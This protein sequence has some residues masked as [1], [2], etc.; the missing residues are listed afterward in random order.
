MGGQV[1][2]QALIIHG[3]RVRV[4]P[5]PPPTWRWGAVPGRYDMRARPAY[6]LIRKGRHHVRVVALVTRIGGYRQ[7]IQSVGE[8]VRDD[9]V[10]VPVA[11]RP[12]GSTIARSCLPQPKARGSATPTAPGLAA[13]NVA[14]LGLLCRV[15]RL[16]HC[17]PDRLAPA[18][19]G[20]TASFLR[21]DLH[22]RRLARRAIRRPCQR[23]DVRRQA[24]EPAA[25]RR[26]PDL[27]T[28]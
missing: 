18:L 22:P 19:A 6:A 25:R 7:S 27:E 15:H 26:A 5:A 4:P 16:P 24:P 21:P 8:G 3:S 11:H 9:T 13:A 17:V 10:H 2:D 1:T 20:G 14:T 28:D 23:R 12:Q